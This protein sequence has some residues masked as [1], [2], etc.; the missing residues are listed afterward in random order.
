MSTAYTGVKPKLSLAQ[1]INMS[2]GFFGI[3][4]GW[5]LAAG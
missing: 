1:I 3:Q 5:D 2:V 4:F